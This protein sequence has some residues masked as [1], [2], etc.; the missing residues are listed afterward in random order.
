MNEGE[1]V[2]KSKL[3]GRSE[4]LLLSLV[5]SLA[6]VG[7]PQ[8][9]GESASQN[10]CSSPPG[11]GVPGMPCQVG[12][13]KYTPSTGWQPGECFTPPPSWPHSIF[14]QGNSSRSKGLF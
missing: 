3:R 12:C 4:L 14:L 8:P 10:T 9:S 5:L 1:E 6:I 13:Y 11:F 2:M 7:Y